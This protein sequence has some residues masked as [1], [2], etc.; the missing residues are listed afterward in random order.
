MTGTG[1]Q[2][3]PYKPTT[4][5]E[6][7]SVSTSNSVYIELPENGG[8][9]D[10]N[11]FYPE[12]ITQTI[13]LKGNINGNDWVIK[14][15]AY[16][17]GTCCFEIGNAEKTK[18]HFINCKGLMSAGYFVG[19]ADTISPGAV[20]FDQ[21]K[22]S[23]KFEATGSTTPYFSNL[24]RQAYYYRCSLNIELDDTMLDYALFRYC[25][26]LA[27][28]T[29]V[30]GSGYLQ[31]D[32]SYLAGEI[33]KLLMQRYSNSYY[34]GDSVIDC[35]VGAVLWDSGT[36]AHLLINSDKVAAGASIPSQLTAVTTAQ[37]VDA[38]YLS[39]IGFPIQT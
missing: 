7:L 31:L 8:I 26:I 33:E 10:M 36:P 16:I 6:L 21:C 27:K 37:L 9:F 30:Q 28:I 19:T 38:A 24:G 4:W 15:P 22:F 1:T 11:N 25:N 17:G 23:G 13:T 34:V 3:D 35:N 32:N 5:G 12:G 2:A 18:F 29:G 20:I 39:S 14:N